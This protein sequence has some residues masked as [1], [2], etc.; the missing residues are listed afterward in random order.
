MRFG[1]QIGAAAAPFVRVLMLATGPISYPIGWVL[2]QVLGERHSALFRWVGRWAGP[3]GAGRLV[4]ACWAYGLLTA[5]GEGAALQMR[6]GH[7][8]P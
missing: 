1:L 7:C 8:R 4:G 6:A 5:R 2:D 3:L